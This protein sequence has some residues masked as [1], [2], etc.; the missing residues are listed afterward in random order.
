M[1]SASNTCLPSR[2]GLYELELE[3]GTGRRSAPA[4]AL[5]LVPAPAAV[6]AVAEAPELEACTDCGAR[7]RPEGATLE[8]YPDTVP[9]WGNGQCRRCDYLAAGKDPEDRFITVA[10]TAY[11]SGLRAGFEAGRTRRGIPT[12]GSRAGRTPIDEFI[13]QLPEEAAS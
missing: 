13:S 10:R 8:Q 3:L 11:L 6:H 2:R 1:S 9:H 5:H 4:R 12:A 7:M